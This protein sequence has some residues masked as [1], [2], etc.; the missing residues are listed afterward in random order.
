[1]KADIKEGRE[2]ARYVPALDHDRQEGRPGRISACNSVEP[3]LERQLLDMHY[4]GGA[5]TL[6]DELDQPSLE[7]ARVTLVIEQPRTMSRSVKLRL[8]GFQAGPVVAQR[9]HECL[10]FGKA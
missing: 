6:R 1:V 10:V 7:S 9:K 8:Q 4:Q 5:R 2:Q 3:L